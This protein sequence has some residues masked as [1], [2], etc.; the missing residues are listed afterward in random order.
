MQ[1]LCS[2]MEEGCPPRPREERASSPG[3]EAEEA[4]GASAEQPVQA[5]LCW[6]VPVGFRSR[7]Q[8]REDTTGHDDIMSGR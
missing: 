2:A 3:P 8:F 7:R 1:L 4:C 5:A 6:S